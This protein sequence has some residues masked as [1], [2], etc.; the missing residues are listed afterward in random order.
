MLKRIFSCS[1]EGLLSVPLM[2]ESY[3][4]N[5]ISKRTLANQDVNSYPIKIFG[6]FEKV[7]K[8]RFDFH[9]LTFIHDL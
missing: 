6:G 4:E 5:Q 7:R 9:Q 3:N 1:T 2:N 8:V